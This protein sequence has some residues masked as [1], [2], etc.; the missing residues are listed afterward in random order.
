MSY[1][2]L[3]LC[4]RYVIYHLRLYGVSLR[5][6]GRRLG[7]HHSTISRELDRNGS[8]HAGAVYVHEV[9]QQ[10]A[11]QRRRWARA[12]RRRD[13]GRLYGYVVSRLRRDWSPEQ[14]A[15][16]LRLD[17]PRDGRMRVS[18]ET[19]YQWVYRDGANGGALYRYLRRRHRRRR[20]QGRYG[21]GRGLIRGRVSIAERPAIVGQRARFGDWEGDT[22]EGA[23]GKGGVASLV[24]RKSRYLITIPTANKFAATMARQV[25][26][27]FRKVPRQARKTLT[28]DNGKEFADFKN[29]ERHTGLTVFF[30]DPYAA[31]QRGTNENTN[32]L[33]RQYLPKK[34]DFRSLS[35][36]ELAAVTK[37]LNHRPRKCLGYRSPH[38]VFHTALNGALDT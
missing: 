36:V 6:I 19:I 34:S 20:R 26:K 31:W 21:A 10:R 7:R 32:G 33:L 29:I 8:P 30:A 38:E 1:E 9:A 5:E 2:H 14:V 25:R 22:V 15:G 18:P 12:C 4:E 16:R 35:C 3:K 11:H 13:H 23:R 24:E 27:A 28:L 37:K 17:F